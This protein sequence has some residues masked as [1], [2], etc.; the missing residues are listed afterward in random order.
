MSPPKRYTRFGGIDVA[1]NRHMVCLLDRDGQYLLRPKTFTNDAEGYQNLLNALKNAGR[2]NTILVGMEATG[3]YWY[4]L[5]DFLVRQGYTVAVLN[6]IQTALQ[7]K[8]AIRKCKTDKADAFH[9]ASLLKNGD[10]KPALVPGEL[11]MTARQLTRLRYHL[12]GTTTRI[13]QRLR[14]K[15]HPVWPEYETLLANPFCQTGK[16]LWRLA[17]TPQDVLV[18]PSEQ[19]ADL[20]RRTSRGKYDQK[21]AQGVRQAAEHSVGLH[22]G[23]EGFRASIR[24]LLDQLEA[25]EPIRTRLEQHIRRLAEQLPDY[26]LTLPGADPIRAVSLYGEVD[27]IQTFTAPSQ[28]VA[29][30]GLDPAVFQTGT[31]DA[32][33]RAI[34]KRGSPYLRRTLWGMAHRAIYLE[35]D[36][37]DYWLRKRGQGKHHLAAVTAAAA[38]LARIAWRI[39][40]DKRPYDPNRNHPFS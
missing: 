15:L 21:L 39:L 11:A 18:V 32:P 12:I 5:H 3:H 29:F 7:A 28:L 2:A 16:S 17:P 36:L 37:R 1:K 25:L 24:I 22:R 26:L 6:P 19:L 35:G 33:R 14:S 30:A 40:T 4:G 10:Y 31:Y 8:K 23:L 38:K 20:I 34:A 27:P 9:I 13:K